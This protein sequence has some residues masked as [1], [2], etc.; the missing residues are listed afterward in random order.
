MRQSVK[1]SPNQW[2]LWYDLGNVARGAEQRHAYARARAL[3][4]RENGI[5]LR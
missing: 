1:N 5:P 2:S 4:P 3:D